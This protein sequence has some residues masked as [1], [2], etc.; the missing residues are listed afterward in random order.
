M[1]L[2][3]K[4]KLPLGQPVQAVRAHGPSP[5]CDGVGNG[6]GD[7][8]GDGVGFSLGVGAGVGGAGVGAGVGSPPEVKLPAGHKLQE[9]APALL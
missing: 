8:V 3:L 1:L 9:A 6:V 4:Q 7:G 2:P 5:A